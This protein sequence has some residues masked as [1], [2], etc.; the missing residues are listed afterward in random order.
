MAASIQGSPYSIGYVELAYAL[1]TGMNYSAVQNQEGNFILPTV[2]STMAAVSEEATTLPSGNE[3]W[4][5]VSITNPPGSES[6]PIASFTYLLLH[7]DLSENPSMT[8][9]KAQKLVDFIRWAITDGQQFAEPLGYVPLPQE[10]VELNQETLNS[11]TFSGNPIPSNSTS[12]G[13]PISTNSTS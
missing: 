13:N 9:D 2:N 10:V 6:Y 5:N 12:S 11:L 7:Q 4:E 8:E 1:T 3:S